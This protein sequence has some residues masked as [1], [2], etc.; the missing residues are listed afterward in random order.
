M[1][2]DP[3]WTEHVGIGPMIGYTLGLPR[4]QLFDEDGNHL[5]DDGVYDDI[6]PLGE[7]GFIDLL[8]TALDVE[9]S[10]DPA[11][12]TRAWSRRGY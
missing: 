6:R 10:I 1:L 8:T 2:I 11:D 3:V 9:W 7:G 4:R 12:V 5:L